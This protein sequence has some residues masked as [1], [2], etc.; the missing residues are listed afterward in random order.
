MSLGLIYKFTKIPH[1]QVTETPQ[2]IDFIEPSITEPITRPENGKVDTIKVLGVEMEKVD[3]KLVIR[4]ID[5]YRDKVLS[6]FLDEFTTEDTTLRG[7]KVEYLE[8]LRKAEATG[9]CS[10]CS[11]NAIQDKYYDVVRS[12]M[13]PDLS[14]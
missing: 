8:E 9:N 5:E 3:G 6:F 4:R 13:L 12:M 10:D 1:I 7:I 14:A 11:K 2:P